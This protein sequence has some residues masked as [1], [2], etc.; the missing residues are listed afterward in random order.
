MSSAFHVNRLCSVSLTLLLVICY[1][2]LLSDLIVGNLNSF[3]LFVLVMLTYFAY[4]VLSDHSA[5][6]SLGPIVILMC[7]LVFLTLLKPNLIFVT[8]LLAAH[9]LASHGMK[10]CARAAIAA[11][12]FGAVIMALPCIYFGSWMIWRDWYNYMN[13]G[14]GKLL[15]A[16]S[17]GNYSTVI[18]ASQALGISVLSTIVVVAAILFT[19]GL[20]AMIM[21]ISH[22][23]LSLKAMWRA[24]VWSLRDPYLSVAIGVTATLAL[25]PLVWY[26]YYVISLLPALW[27][28]T[29]PHH[30]LYLLGVLS[31][32][33]T[34]GGL[35]AILKYL[36]GWA[37][38]APFTIVIG[39]VPL[40][41]GMLVVIV[42]KK[43]ST[44]ADS[45]ACIA[46]AP[47]S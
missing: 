40:W 25:S 8:L 3:Q 20:G 13:I 39:W 16:T 1:G 31:I 6:N 37:G 44:P 42:Y 12:I 9:L 22:D 14:G 45:E 24:T 15:Y 18:L 11:A 5:R 30:Y 19:L 35:G 7:T 41:A 26:H 38:L 33:L 10:V 29:A 23:G 36:F 32:L 4:R 21:A 28:L 17:L 47:H 43:N 2:P 46:T 27:L 34:S